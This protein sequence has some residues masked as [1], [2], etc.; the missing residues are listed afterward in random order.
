M[1]E[2][3]KIRFIPMNFSL[4]TTSDEIKK[5]WELIAELSPVVPASSVIPEW[6]KIINQYS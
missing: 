5:H 6:Y 3:P 1:K 2:I 4:P